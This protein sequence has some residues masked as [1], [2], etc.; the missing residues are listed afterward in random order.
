MM[1]MTQCS[2]TVY[3]EAEEVDTHELAKNK[4]VENKIVYAVTK[5]IVKKMDVEKEIRETFA[6]ISVEVK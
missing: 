2:D 5:P 4:N 3:D 6:A 1:L